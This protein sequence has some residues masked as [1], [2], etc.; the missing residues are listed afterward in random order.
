MTESSD[1]SRVGVHRRRRVRLGEMRGLEVWV[2][3]LWAVAMV[4]NLNAYICQSS[5]FI[6]QI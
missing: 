1:L 6:E 4:T 3:T 2:S 5:Y